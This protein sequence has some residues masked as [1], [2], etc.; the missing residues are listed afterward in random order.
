M[1][2]RRKVAAAVG[3]AAVAGAAV[4]L[5]QYVPPNERG[6]AVTA[7]DLSGSLVGAG[8][9]SQQAAMQGWTAGYSGV[10]PGVTVDYDPVGSGGGRE[11]FIAGGI[12]FAG[13]DAPLD[14]EE[15]VAARERCG[16][17][18][19][20]MPNY[21]SPI[22]V[23][24]N[25]PGLPELGLSPTTLARVFDGRITTWN[26]PAIAADNPG[27]SLPDL[28]ITPVNRSDES[29]TTE[30]FTEYLAA[31]AG[32]AWPYEPDGEWPVAGGEAAQGN[33]GVVAAVA[34]GQGTVGYADLSQAGD[35]GVARIGVG[36]DFVAPTPDAA[37]AVVEGSEPLPG[38]GPYDFALE[39]D[40][41]TAESGEY[42]IVL[43]S[44]HLGCI[45]YEDQLT[46]DLVADFMTYVTS[47]QGQAAAAEVAGSAPISDALRDQARTAIDAISTAS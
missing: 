3:V 27:A 18:V 47:K 34:G 21:I 35:L 19:F 24:H 29:G 22:A 31:A 14:E 43:V 45:G 2:A 39:L 44:Y 38:R 26:D 13:S 6:Q 11:Q 1:S 9:S 8:A 5:S 20:E 42:P 15:L 28:Q 36:G 16:G 30:N 37:A 12:D 33:S 32:E 46:A 23:V 25:V 41:T 4:A 17:E 40:R 10:Q 7:G